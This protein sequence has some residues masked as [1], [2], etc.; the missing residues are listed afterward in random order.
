[1]GTERAWASQYEFRRRLS[2]TGQTENP[3][4]SFIPEQNSNWQKGF[5]VG[6]LLIELETK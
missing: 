2:R 6:H 3:K 4:I 5:L 1:M